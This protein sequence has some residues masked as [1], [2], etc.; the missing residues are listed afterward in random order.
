MWTNPLKVPHLK[1]ECW[2]EALLSAS[3][4]AWRHAGA[5]LAFYCQVLNSLMSQSIFKAECLLLSSRSVRF[6]VV[7]KSRQLPELQVNFS[8]AGNISKSS[9]ARDRRGSWTFTTKVILACNRGAVMYRLLFVELHVLS[10]CVKAWCPLY[11]VLTVFPLQRICGGFL[12]NAKYF[13]TLF[14]HKHT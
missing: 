10:Q 14:Q 8:F 1:A 7:F 13:M 5:I 12:S 9:E 2:K 11:E 3:P 6:V 4:A